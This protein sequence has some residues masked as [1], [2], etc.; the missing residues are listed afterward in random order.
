M[1]LNDLLQPEIYLSLY[2]YRPNRQKYFVAENPVAQ[3][4]DEVD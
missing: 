1:N 4:H 3:L 2:T